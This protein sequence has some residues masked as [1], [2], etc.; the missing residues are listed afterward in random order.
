MK[1]DVISLAML[2]VWNSGTTEIY[3]LLI[4]SQV[5]LD[6]QLPAAVIPLFRVAYSNSIMGTHKISLFVEFLGWLSFFLMLILNISLMLDMSFGDSEWIGSFR[7][8]GTNMAVPF[9]LIIMV[10][11]FSLGFMLWF[12][13]TPIRC[14]NHKVE[15]Q[16]WFEESETRYE[17]AEHLVS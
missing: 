2:Y 14:S 8:I 11:I 9:I 10:A 16:K 1:T 4:F 3:Q 12:I 13:A 7:N 15:D 5:M 6:M 17:H